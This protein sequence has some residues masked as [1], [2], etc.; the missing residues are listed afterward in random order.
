MRFRGNL[1]WTDYHAFAM[2]VTAVML[3][4][5]VATE[6]ANAVVMAAFSS[7]LDWPKWKRIAMAVLTP[8]AP[9]ALGFEELA[10]RMEMEANAET[11]GQ[12]LENEESFIGWKPAALLEPW[13]KAHR[14]RYLRS[15]LRYLHYTTTRITNY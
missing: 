13:E 7:D 11:I 3:L 12:R 15:R 10:A 8:L 14:I 4:S 2:A 6:I 1:L 9:L 5:V